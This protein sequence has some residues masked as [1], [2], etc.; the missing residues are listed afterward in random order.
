MASIRARIRLSISSK[1]A[2]V[3]LSRDVVG[4]STT[5]QM[6][7]ENTL[8][9]E[10]YDPVVWMRALPIDSSAFWWRYSFRTIAAALRQHGVNSSKLRL[11]A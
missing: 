2:R 5:G 3:R 7:I 11:V 9:L 8:S 6:A 10:Q 4:P 1:S